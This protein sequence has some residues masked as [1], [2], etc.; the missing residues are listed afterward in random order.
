MKFN[1]ESELVDLLKTNLRNT[2]HR[3]NVEI[4]DEVS[5]GF[6]R[7]DIV[8]CEYIQI[9]KN[10]ISRTAL[11]SFAINIYQI[12]RNN[13]GVDFDELYDITRSHK[14]SIVDALNTLIE[15]DYIETSGGGFKIKNYYEKPIK[16]SFAIEA[17][18]KNWKQALIQAYRYKW[19]AE[20]AYVVLDAYYVNPAIQNI[21]T[22]RK[23]NVG[24]ASL[25]R[26]GDLIRYYNPNKNKPID[27]NMQIL[28]Y[29]FARK[30]YTLAK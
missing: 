7:A 15:G 23:Y 3:Q 25:S 14:K 21:E 28:L 8:I 9:T 17:K 5:F 12:I 11:D 13:E 16:N 18:I 26:D 10:N 22:F 1:S 24:L 4:F 27:S 20:F 2:F 30:N 29:E 6:G 19:F